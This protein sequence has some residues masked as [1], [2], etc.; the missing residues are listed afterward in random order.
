MK[1]NKT[2]KY[3]AILVGAM[4]LIA[5]TGKQAGWFGKEKEIKVSA[6]TVFRQNI[7]EVVSASGKVQPEVELKLSADVSGEIVLLNVKEGDHVEK[8]MLLVRIKPEAYQSALERM[9]ASVNTSKAQLASEKSRLAMAESSFNKADLAYNRSKKLFEQGAVSAADFETA[10]S[11][12]E[13]AKAETES[14]RQGIFAAEFNLKSAEASLNESRENLSK[15]TILAPVSG[16]ISKLSKELGERVVGTNMMEGTE[17]LRIANLNEMEVNVDVN[18][19]DI[20]RVHKGDTA[21]IEVDAYLNRKF[22]GLVT[23][24]SN[25]ANSIAGSTDQV[26]NFSVKVRI[27]RDSYLDLLKGKGENES[28][29]RPG[30]SAAVDIQTKTVMNVLS[31]PVQSVTTRDSITPA[32]MLK[33]AGNDSSNGGMMGSKECVFVL[34]SG[35]ARL[36]EVRTGIQDNSLIEI[37]EG[38]KEHEV[39]ISGPYS[40]VSKGLTDSVKVTVVPKEELFEVK[41]D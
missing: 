38:L 11:A 23:E 39:V 18:E 40:E 19:S 34:D 36:R 13:V 15:T 4:L 14:A 3:L 5:I 28:P 33:S 27:M 2:L 17:I 31:I 41:E 20:V 10:K 35:R 21:L 25:T 29:F 16:T 6:D 24:I 26:T 12:W 32:G 9:N 8:G 7:T 22:K 37:L 30:M 1:K